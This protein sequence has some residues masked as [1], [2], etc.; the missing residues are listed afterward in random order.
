VRRDALLARLDLA[1]E[2]RLTLIHAPAGYG[3][4]S[5]LSQWRNRVDGDATLVAWLTLERDDAD[6]R[7]LAQYIAL[8]LDGGV[9]ADAD[10]KLTDL[11]PRAA[12]SAL[13]N[14][15]AREP[16]RVVLILDDLHLAEG[17]PVAEFLKALIQLAPQNCHF[18]I[19]SRDYPWLGQ[20][21]LAAEEQLLELHAEDLKFSADEAQALLARGDAA[22]LAGEDVARIVERTEGWAIA[23]QLTSLSLKRGAD[24]RQLMAHFGGASSDLARYLS[25]QVLTTLP[26]ETQQIV[27]RTALL[28]HLT[29]DTINLLCDRQDGW[30]VLERLE[31]QGAVLTPLSP[32]RQAYRYHQLFAEY[33]RERLARSDAALFRTLH[34]RAALW[35]AGRGEV[36]DAV[37]HAI[38]ASDGA[39]I[40]TTLEDAGGWRLIPQGL[41]GLVERGLAELPA[42]TIAA[43]PRLVLARIYLEV[44]R[45]HM[46]AARAEYDRLAAAVDPDLSADLRTEIRVV[47]DVLD[48]YENLP[49][50]FDTL[51]EREA[52]LRT[53]PTDDHLVLANFN[54]ALGAKYY[55]GGWLERALEPTLASRAHYRALGSLYSDLFTRFSEAR[56]KRAQGRM[57]DAAAILAT[58]RAEI[59]RG[60]GPRSDL[61]AN[62]AAFEAELLY[63]Q[64]RIPEALA[65]LDWALPHMELFDG[66]VDVYAAAYFTAARA[67]AGDGDLDAAQ[68]LLARARLTAGRRRFHQL[69]LLTD[70]CELELLLHHAELEAAHALADQIDLDALA[71]PMR[72]E[73]PR[74][75]AVAVAAAMSRARLR[76]LGGDHVTALAELA[77]MHRWASQHGA[78]RLLIDVNLLRAHGLRQAGD[79]APAQAA[80]DEAVGVAMFQGIVRP[81]VDARRF[82]S[83]LVEAALGGAPRIDRFRAQFL[84]DLSRGIASRPAAPVA[85]DALNDAEAAILAH[86]SYGYS[87]KEIA[88]LIGMSPDTVKYRLK[89]VF[90]KIGVNK[91]RDA[92]RVSRE[93][94]FLPVA[95]TPA[96]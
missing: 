18:V 4:T 78:G 13:I 34:H 52:L 26:E 46:D 43:R 17:A 70:L 40:A 53:L 49:M 82:S 15:L 5:L 3:K 73:S 22:E 92:V 69:T 81:F 19:A 93:R 62:C 84:R 76:L 75:R 56:I 6:P 96:P 88:R 23:L 32:D 36:V 71:E 31:Q 66:W 20:S 21:I 74:Y 12:L 68:A 11:P 7:R 30:L 80:F 29:G 59:E 9:D 41:Q 87:N 25:E 10:R 54:E 64:D 47:G 65:L 60:F 35:F 55:E 63:E 1:L 38:Q 16:R 77:Q 72:E 61:A 2:R 95:G 48:E 50:T 45:G 33:L 27:L 39:L 67:A 28:D 42:A 24:H 94:G 8:A 91:R 37:N 51:L 89:S 58:A 90:R 85:D 44:K 14:R 57:Q 86:L 83:D 79:A